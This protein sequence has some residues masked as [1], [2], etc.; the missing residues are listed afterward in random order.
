MATLNVSNPVTL[1]DS[2]PIPD[3]NPISGTRAPSP[4]PWAQLSFRRLV[5][6][7][8]ETEEIHGWDM[9][10]SNYE[11]TIGRNRCII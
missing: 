11:F 10:L 7:G 8:D 3:T 5:T 2:N 6:A 1:Y 4:R 9:D